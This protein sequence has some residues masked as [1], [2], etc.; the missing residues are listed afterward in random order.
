MHTVQYV[1]AAAAVDSYDIF[2]VCHGTQ[3]ASSTRVLATDWYQYQY[4]GTAV[5]ALSSTQRRRL[6][7]IARCKVARRCTP[8]AIATSRGETPIFWGTIR[9]HREDIRLDCC[10]KARVCNCSTFHTCSILPIT[11]EA[12]HARAVVAAQSGVRAKAGALSNT[13][14]CV[15]KRSLLALLATFCKC[16]NRLPTPS[17]VPR[18]SLVARPQ[19]P[20][21]HPQPR[22]Q[23]AQPVILT[24]RSRST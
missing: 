14:V 23:A 13:E 12:A 20:W 17:A 19:A 15:Y 1:P 6:R 16:I 8:F 10:G 2:A 21:P 3:L 18:A 22:R 9:C 4:L 11:H 7:H 24:P 5:R